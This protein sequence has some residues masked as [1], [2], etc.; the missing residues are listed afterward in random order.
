MKTWLFNPFKFIAGNKALLLGIGAM[1][2]TT[3]VCLFGKLHLDGVIDVH[4]GRETQSYFYFIEPLIDWLCFVVPLYIFARNFSVSS[5]RFI[6]VA[7]TAALA[8]YPMLFVVVLNM[9][10][11]THSKDPQKIVN[12]IL[13]HPVM[14]LQIILLGLLILPFIIWTVALMYNAYSLSANLKGTKAVWSFVA[15]FIIAEI[16][17]KVIFSLL[18]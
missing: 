9:L 12:D 2:I 18:I 17:S 13:G 11:P 6:D 7:G 15:S 14:L 4:E 3:I 8:R 1:L 16:L 10:F 5:I